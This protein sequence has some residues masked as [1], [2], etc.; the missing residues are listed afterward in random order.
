VSNGY[1]LPP[2]VSTREIDELTPCPR[3]GYVRG[4]H[5][6]IST[7]CPDGKGLFEELVEWHCA[8]VLEVS[9]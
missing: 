1:N 4:A 6:M 3:C 2:G 8:P 7:V 5:G 9:L